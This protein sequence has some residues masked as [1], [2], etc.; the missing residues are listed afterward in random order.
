MATRRR[1][2][3][4]RAAA[5]VSTARHGSRHDVGE[6][7]VK[8]KADVL[9]KGVGVDAVGRDLPRGGHGQTRADQHH[10]SVGNWRQR[11]HASAHA[12]V[13]KHASKATPS[14]WTWAGWGEAGARMGQARRAGP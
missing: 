10:A 14:R 7:E 2:T 13:V 1:L 4:L 3:Y 5:H 8:T 9:E 12:A 11:S 6:Y